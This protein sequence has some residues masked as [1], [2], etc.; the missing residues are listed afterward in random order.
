MKLAFSLDYTLGEGWMLPWVEGM[1]HGK[2][3]ASACSQCNKAQFPPTRLCPNCRIPSDGWTELSGGA[4]ILFRTTG[5]DGDFALARFD[6]SEGAVVVRA[7]RLSDTATRGHLNA[8]AEGPPSLC[9]RPEDQ[10]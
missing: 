4:A 3:V 10:E 6:G 1:R 8:I 5:S 2:A 7:E 9:L